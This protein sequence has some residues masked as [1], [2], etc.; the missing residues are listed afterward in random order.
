M[1][2]RRVAAVALGA[3]IGASIRWAVVRVLGTS[4]LDG[5]LLIVNVVGCLA[6]GAVSQLPPKDMTTTSKS[7]LGAGLCGSLT[8]W[9]SLALQ[10]AADIRSGAWSE[11]AWW[12][13]VSLVVGL[14]AAAVGQ[15]LGRR[16]WEGPVRAAP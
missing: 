16:R 1:D 11:A 6:L 7:F 4:A 5:A 14:A 8:S 9:S 15:F 3:V 12:L 2:A 13:A 10:A